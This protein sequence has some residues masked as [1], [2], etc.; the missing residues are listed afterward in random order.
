M[1]HTIIKILPCLI[2]Y[3]RYYRVS[4]YKKDITVSHANASFLML[5]LARKKMG[6]RFRNRPRKKKVKIIIRQHSYQK[7][8]ERCMLPTIHQRTQ[9]DEFRMPWKSELLL[10]ATITAKPFFLFGRYFGVPRGLIFEVENICNH[11]VE[12]GRTKG[13]GATYSYLNFELYTIIS[14]LAPH[15]KTEFCTSTCNPM[16]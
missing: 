6:T 11:G 14:I 1:S 15:P 5:T 10:M 12:A 16:G 8:R 3:S 9:V 7:K 13:C 4:Y 2:L